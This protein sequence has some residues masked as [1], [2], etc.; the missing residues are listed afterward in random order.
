MLLCCGH[1]LWIQLYQQCL[2]ASPVHK[3]KGAVSDSCPQ[4]MSWGGFCRKIS[5]YN[6]LSRSQLGQVNFL[7]S[8]M[9]RRRKK[10][11][12][13]PNS[14]RTSHSA[15]NYHRRNDNQNNNKESN[16]T[17]QNG[18][19]QRSTNCKC[20]R[21]P[22]HDWTPLHGW[23]G[24]TLPSPLEKTASSCQKISHFESKA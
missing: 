13:N 10:K 24:W 14:H 20:G 17:S 6:R 4:E 5:K 11:K 18:H 21:E 9:E 23:W 19:P 2:I 8:F 7:K 15:S 22:G 3:T 1:F 12:N 16:P